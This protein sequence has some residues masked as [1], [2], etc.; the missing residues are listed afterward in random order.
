MNAKPA[1]AAARPGYADP[2]WRSAR[3]LAVTAVLAALAV[4]GCSQ[5]DLAP[6]KS[7]A[8]WLDPLNGVPV[9]S[10][11]AAQHR[12]GFRLRLPRGMRP[13]QVLITPGVPAAYRVVI[14]VYRTRFGLADVFEQ[15]G[16]LTQ[17]QF[18]QTIRRVVAV[19]ISEGMRG[20]QTAV[21]LRGRVPAL[22]T[23][24][25]A[26]RLSLIEWFEAGMRYTISGPSLSKRDCVVL[27]DRFG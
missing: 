18:R 20:T 1:A 15:R 27:A 10:V 24:S 14:L 26:G 25:D 23:T 6:S 4:T 22:I 21:T 16:Q 12:A 11:A 19:S 8:N 2:A 9:A 3:A 5:Q 7:A 13:D 17:R